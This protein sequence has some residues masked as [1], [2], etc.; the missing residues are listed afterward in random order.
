[1]PKKKSGPVIEVAELGAGGVN[2]VADPLEMSDQELV[3]AQ[4]AE[5]YRDRGEAGVRK[6]P[7][8]RPLNTVATDAIQG[9]LAVELGQGG[10]GNNLAN[11]L[12]GAYGLVVVA[13]SIN[14]ATFAWKATTSAG[15]TWATT[16]AL[17]HAV[18]NAN[19]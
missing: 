14:P 13:R 8:Y 2:L 9:I 7:A 17:T 6:R 4:N 12:S 5:P 11:G 10:A 18:A 16:T 3:Q 19:Y 1:V 15:A